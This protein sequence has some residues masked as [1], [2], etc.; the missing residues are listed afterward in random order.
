MLTILILRPQFNSPKATERQLG[1]IPSEDGF[2]EDPIRQ[3]HLKYGMS[4][5]NNDCENLTFLMGKQRL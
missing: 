1:K 3:N 2:T 5:Q 4:N